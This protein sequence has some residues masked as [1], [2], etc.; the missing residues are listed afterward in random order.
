MERPNKRP[1]EPVIMQRE[2]ERGRVVVD[3]HRIDDRTRCELLV[4]HEVGGTWALYP[5]GWGKFG[6]RLPRLRQSGWR[7]PC[8]TVLGE[9]A[10]PGPRSW[11]RS[12]GER[13]ASGGADDGA[14][15]PET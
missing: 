6:V 12:T 1:P 10:E 8:W 5:H 7:R 14:Q 11:P 4:V 15:P 9:P 13:V 3:G 2:N